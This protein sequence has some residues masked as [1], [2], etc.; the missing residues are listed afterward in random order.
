[1][2]PEEIPG[3]IAI[4]EICVN[5][6]ESFPWAIGF[7]KLKQHP[8]VTLLAKLSKAPQCRGD[9]RIASTGGGKIPPWVLLLQ[10]VALLAKLSKA[11]QSRIAST[12]GGKIPPW[13]L[14]L[15]TVALLA[16]L[17]KAPQC[18]GDSR[19]ASTGGGKIP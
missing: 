6:C 10:T 4:W 11:P 17:S 7:A 2:D 1:M 3:A 13:V 18:R 8:I 12:G 16:K 14:L 19:I 15:Q 5:N 9:S